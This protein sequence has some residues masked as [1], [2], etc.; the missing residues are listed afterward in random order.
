MKCVA[1]ISKKFHRLAGTNAVWLELYAKRWK[2]SDIRE[3]KF[4]TT[5][6]WRSKFIER[7][8]LDARNTTIAETDL[9]EPT[10]TE[11][12]KHVRNLY[13]K[14][15]ILVLSTLQVM[16][17]VER[18]KN[19]EDIITLGGMH[20][21]QYLASK[22]T[23]E[24]RNERLAHAAVRVLSHLIKHVITREALRSFVE[25]LVGLIPLLLRLVSY[26]SS[27][28]GVIASTSSHASTRLTENEEIRIAAAESLGKLI[29]H[30]G[31]Y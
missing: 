29:C 27:S 6:D 23:S 17:H 28:N 5:F 13:A 20:R 3:L 9:S 8:K 12:M 4:Y 10:W 26:K 30:A 14:D 18:S 25:E 2:I 7:R 21:L 15:E 1:R 24:K 16:Y 31:N 11:M 19:K 22:F